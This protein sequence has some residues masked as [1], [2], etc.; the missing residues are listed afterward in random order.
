M[1]KLFFVVTSLFIFLAEGCS[2]LKITSDYDRSAD[3]SNL[4]TFNIISHHEGAPVPNEISRLSISYI[5]ESI[6][7]EMMDR[8][9]TLSDNSDIEVY[10]YIK[11]SETTEYQATTVG[12]YGGNP[13]YGGSPYY[14]GYHGGYGYTSTYVQAIDVTEGAL[15]I[16]LVNSSTE[17]ALWQGVAT[18]SVAQTSPSD[19]DIHQIVHSIFT[20][21]K[22]K[23]E[24]VSQESPKGK[25]HEKQEYPDY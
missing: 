8:G 11:L 6:I 16:E 25:E 18:K 22:W 21:Y 17:K 20:T 4:K 12:T 7:D 10:Y 23:A 15:I 24:L 3:F 19:R 1:K 13:Y 5:E 9:Y 14:Y 2:D